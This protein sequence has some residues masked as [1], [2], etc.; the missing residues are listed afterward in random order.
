M[1]IEIEQREACDVHKDAETH[2]DPTDTGKRRQGSYRPCLVG[3]RYFQPHL[4]L[5]K[6]NDKEESGTY[7]AVH[8]P[9]IFPAFLAMDRRYEFYLRTVLSLK[10]N[11][12]TRDGTSLREHLFI[13]TG[14]RAW[15]NR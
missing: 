3:V 14:E 8:E 13:A 2:L 10:R 7:G 12:R 11:R 1:E 5:L 15:S 4:G 6:A 9:I